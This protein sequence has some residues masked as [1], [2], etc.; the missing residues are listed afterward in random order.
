MILLNTQ[1]LIAK[2]ASGDR[3]AQQQLYKRLNAP[4]MGVCVR[5]MKDQQDAEDVLLE[6][7]Y[8]IFKNL[9]KFKYESEHGFFGWAKRIMVNEALMKLRK[10]KEI[11]LLA[12]NEDWDKEMD[13]SPLMKLQTSDLLKMISSIPVGYRTVFNMYEVEG[14]SH[15]EISQQLGVSVGTSKSQLFKAK[16]MLREM[17]DAK[18]EGYGS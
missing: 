5:Y 15:Q 8:K 7:F 9:K 13:V 16:K 1:D 17:L 6:G 14:Y 10:N 12:I 4:M 18:N 3:K 2:S 11:Q